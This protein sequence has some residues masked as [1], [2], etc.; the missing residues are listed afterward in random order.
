[1]TV[2]RSYLVTVCG[3]QRPS[4]Q[5][6]VSINRPSCSLSRD[7]RNPLRLRVASGSGPQEPPNDTAGCE[8]PRGVWWMTGPVGESLPDFASQVTRHGQGFVILG[9]PRPNS[10]ERKVQGL[11]RMDEGQSTDL[12]AASAT[13][14]GNASARLFGS[15]GTP[16]IG[17]K[18]LPGGNS[19][20]SGLLSEGEC[21]DIV[22]RAATGGSTNK[23]A[24]RQGREPP[25]APERSKSPRRTQPVKFLCN[26]CLTETIRDVNPHA[27]YHGTVF[28]ECSGCHIKHKVRDNL[29]LFHE[30][31]GPVF[32]GAP[33][34]D[35]LKTKFGWLRKRSW[36][37][38]DDAGGDEQPRPGK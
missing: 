2:A 24:A 38:E 7:F 5:H 32:P 6:S 14:S 25:V 27:W 16:T 22:L 12:V 19:H 8:L 13:N 10:S 26:I 20:V 3:I 15:V 28:L 11:Q 23:L 31:S 29:N 18:L 30:L 21:R 34:V 17:F 35:A 37:L 1:M 4:R 36:R 33:S 9:E